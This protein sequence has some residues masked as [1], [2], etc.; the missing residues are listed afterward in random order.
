[1]L[2]LDNPLVRASDSCPLCDGLKP[3]GNVAC[4][5]CYR[6]AEM[7]HGNPVAEKIIARREATLQAECR[8]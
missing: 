5:P 3:V 1:M 6:N 8:A 7:R 2:Q 4:W